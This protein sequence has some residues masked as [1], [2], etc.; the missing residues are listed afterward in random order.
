V[1]YIK[2][3]A[4][5]SYWPEEHVA[6]KDGEA[7]VTVPAPTKVKCQST[8]ETLGYYI[9]ETPETT[10]GAGTETLVVNVAALPA[11]A[12]TGVV[13]NPDRTAFTKY[14]YISLLPLEKPKG[15]NEM[16][17]YN[18]SASN[19]NTN[20]V[21]GKYLL[22]PVPLGGKYRLIVSADAAI[23]LSDEFTLDA[24]HAIHQTDL[25]L[26]AG[27][28]F[29]GT[30]VGPD[31]KPVS[32]AKVELTYESPYSHS[33]GSSTR[34]DV[35]GEYRFAHVN[36]DLPGKY[37]LAVEPGTTTQGRLWR[38]VAPSATPV[39][40]QVEAG[41]AVRGRVVNDA[42]GKPMGNV[43]LRLMPTDWL[44]AAYTNGIETTSNSA[45]EFSLRNL[46]PIGYTVYM[47]DAYP[48]GTVFVK[49]AEGRSVAQY[50][51][52]FADTKLVG[53]QTEAVQIRAVER[54]GR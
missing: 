32:G 27:V 51:S 4:P 13:R 53:G 44:K 47:E 22:S 11:G 20:Q 16:P 37:S 28:S 42:T 29:G 1:D 46:E 54:L 38:T 14:A 8:A 2:P 43:R 45:G 31:G 35:R 10:V 30:V 39:V 48:A 33:F 18:T 3:S 12:V 52:G 19:T 15:L 7:T 25:V 9:A 21:T 36:P 24:G 40:L 23:A 41:V 6:I 50:P 34:T 49:S 17:W 5:G 26:A